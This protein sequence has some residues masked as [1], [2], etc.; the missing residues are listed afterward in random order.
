MDPLVPTILIPA[1]TVVG[2]I[3]AIFMWQRVSKISMSGG[4]VFR[5]ENGRAYLL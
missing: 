2:V 5:S 4:S 3:F 1:S